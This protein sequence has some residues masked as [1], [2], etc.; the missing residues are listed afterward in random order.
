MRKW[1]LTPL[2]IFPTFV[3][4]AGISGIAQFDGSPVTHDALRAVAEG[5]PHRGPDGIFYQRFKDCGFAHLALNADPAN[6]K[7][8][9]LLRHEQDGR[10]WLITADA[11]IDNRTELRSSLGIDDKPIANDDCE[12]ILLAFLKWDIACVSRLIGDFAFAIWDAD[13]QTLFCARDPLGV[14]PLHYTKLS[15]GL[16]V[17]SAAQQILQHPEISSRLNEGTV[18]EYLA[19]AG[20]NLQETFFVGIQSLAAGHTLVARRHGIQVARYW[21]PE[22]LPLIQYADPRLYAEHFREL[23]ITAVTERIRGFERAAITVSGGLDSS[24]IASVAQHYD[25]DT[26]IQGFTQIYDQLVQCD[27]RDYSRHL[28]HELGLDIEPVPTERFWLLADEA[29]FCPQLESPFQSFASCMRYLYERCQDLGITVLLTGHGGDSLLTGSGLSYLDRLL[30]GDLGVFRD[31]RVHAALRHRSMLELVSRYLLRPLIPNT[32][33]AILQTKSPWQD[34]AFPAWIEPQFA[35][36][37][38]LSHRLRTQS[39]LPGINSRGRHERVTEMLHL[40][41]VARAIY[42][43]DRTASEFGLECRHPFLD[44]RLVEYV[45]SLPN[46]QLFHAG[47]TKVVLRNALRGILPEAIRNRQDKTYSTAFVDFSLRKISA[48]RISMLFEDPICAA[49]GFINRFELRRAWE[50]F[51][52]GSRPMKGAM[53]WFPITLETW[54]RR[55]HLELHIS[56]HNQ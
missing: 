1:G 7:T 9:Q 49:L 40:G 26:K 18:G 41:S 34:P 17:A 51:R 48:D 39:R 12:L 37:I 10:V 23:L 32:V 30:R 2:S 15:R 5:A 27:E 52:T 6:K 22:D 33:K 55:Y 29:A 43:L 20:E 45:L 24:S 53:F 13:N 25:T 36:R 50:D 47:K 31:M 56:D 16:C 4:V 8:A 19:G 54:L 28:T 42:Y 35:N 14:K 46:E 38:G 11:R 3:I 21:H 44:R